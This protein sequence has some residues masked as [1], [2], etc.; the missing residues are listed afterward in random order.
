MSVNSAEN[1]IRLTIQNRVAM[2]ALK[3]NNLPETT[4]LDKQ[5]NGIGLKNVLGEVKKVNG[6][7]DLYEENGWV[8]ADVEI[9]S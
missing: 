4:K 6:I 1:N 5:H 3:S 2:K 7:Y 9:A 8:I